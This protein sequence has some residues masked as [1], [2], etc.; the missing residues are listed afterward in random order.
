MALLIDRAPAIGSC[1]EVVAT[2]IIRSTLTLS[3]NAMP[4]P[5]P[6]QY[7]GNSGGGKP[8]GGDSKGDRKR[9]GSHTRTS[10][11]RNRRV[12]RDEATEGVESEANG[13]SG[14]SL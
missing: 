13:E 8:S 7:N 2:R 11:K 9:Q 1:A 3:Y 14:E 5:M 6:S 4:L 12:T 10:T